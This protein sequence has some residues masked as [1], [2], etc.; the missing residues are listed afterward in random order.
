MAGGAMKKIGLLLSAIGMIILFFQNC[1]NQTG[2]D[3]NNNS[4]TPTIIEEIDTPVITTPTTPGG[5]TEPGPV[6]KFDARG[7][8][9]RSLQWNVGNFTCAVIYPN[10][11]HRSEPYVL[12]DAAGSTMG[13]I[14]MA[15][16]D[17]K[18]SEVK[19]FPKS[20]ELRPGAPSGNRPLNM[21]KK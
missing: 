13:K 14:T 18:L 15:C 3:D 4:D 2:Y 9:S 12:T 20:C 7:C 8:P 17:G 5:T 19:A 11:P 21:K 10:L 16:T 6:D 1:A